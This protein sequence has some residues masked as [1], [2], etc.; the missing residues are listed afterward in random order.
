M[1]TR[2]VLSLLHVVERRSVRI[3]T[4]S[5]PGGDKAE[6]GVALLLLDL[7]VPVRDRAG[8]YLTD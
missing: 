1:I 4:E 5:S 2:S 6:V 7:R 3:A 8:L